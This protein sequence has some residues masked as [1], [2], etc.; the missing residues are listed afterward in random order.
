MKLCPSR[1]SIVVLARR[2]IS[3][4][5]EMPATVTGWLVSSWLTSGLMTRLITP[6]LSTVGVKESPTP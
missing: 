4:G 3:G 1:S 2:M 5:T 6:F